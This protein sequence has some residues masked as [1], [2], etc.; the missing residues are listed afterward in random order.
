MPLGEQFR[1]H[2]PGLIKIEVALWKAWLVEHEGDFLEFQYNVHVGEG[3]TPPSRPLSGDPEIDAKMR[4]TFKLWTQRK[5]DVVGL[6]SSETW[7]FEVEDRPGTRA[8]GQLM[9]YEVLLPRSFS[10]R[11][12]I[13]LATIGRRIGQ[14]VLEA[15]EQQGVVVWRVDLP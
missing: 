2:F 15:F 4:E 9:M 1:R 11:G 13:Q 6:T 14:D 7:I 8:L 3:I 12:N 5:I 10:V